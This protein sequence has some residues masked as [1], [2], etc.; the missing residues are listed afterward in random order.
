MSLK[1]ILCVVCF[2]FLTMFAAAAYMQEGKRTDDV[3]VSGN[4]YEPAQLEPTNERV[5]GLKLPEGFQVTKFAEIQNPRM[6]TVSDDG[7][8]YVSQREP[9]TMAM[10][11]DTNNDG[12]ADVQKTVAEKKML[13]GLF[14]HKNKMYFTSVREVF[15]AD[16]KSDGT[17][18]EAKMIISDLPDG[19]QHPNRTLGIGKDGMLYITVGS[20]CNAC[21]EPNDENATIVRAN[22]DSSNR[23]VFASGLRNTIGFGWHPVSKKMYGMDHGIDWLGD[24]EQSEEL[25]ELTEGAKYGWPYVYGDGTIN[26]HPDIP[27]SLGMTKEDWARTSKKPTLL[28]TPHSAPMQMAFYTGA[29]FPAEYKNDAFV[30]MRGSWNRK[31][32]SG[33]EVVRVRF[34]ASGQPKS[35]EPFMTGFLVKGG[36]PDGKDGQFARIAGIAVAK[37]GAL[38]VSDDSNNIIYR[39]AYNK[40][41]QHAQMNTLMNRYGV[42]SMMLPETQNATAQITVSS[43]AFTNNAM[44]PDKHSAYNQDQSPAISWSNA[45]QGAKSFVLMTEDPDALSPKPFVH[46][47]VANIPANVMSLTEG[48]AKTDKLMNGAM[49]GGTNKGNV[50]YYG[51][52]PPAG[53]P[54][55]HY[56]FQIFA[57]DKMLDLPAG[58]NRQALLDAMRGHVLA[59]GELVGTYQRKP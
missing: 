22:L 31:P 39:I 51:P 46:W 13:H 59:K 10:L 58:F 20:T 54:P 45:P 26:K 6:L 2:V 55:H 41:T 42:I 36:S 3:N 49:Q 40:N 17:L 15:V 14:I 21:S 50:G 23:K 1:A 53:E 4:V 27:K 24:N 38:L 35:I 44:I 48:L 29:M 32:P 28:Y 37:D 16:I 9:G 57:L 25:N 52:K 12:V 33:Y 11:R 34:D 47:L 19:G 30:S 5:R 56:H 18:G 8:V 43:N 7:T